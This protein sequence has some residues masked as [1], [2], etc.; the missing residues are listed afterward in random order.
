M[1]A[2]FEKSRAPAIAS[3]AQAA[4]PSTTWHSLTP[5]RLGPKSV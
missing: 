2:S 5:S 3:R 1:P 4:E